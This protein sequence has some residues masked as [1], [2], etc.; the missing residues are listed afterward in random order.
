M[1][2]RS[3]ETLVSFEREAAQLTRTLVQARLPMQGL[4]SRTAGIIA[5]SHTLVRQ[6][7]ELIAGDPRANSQSGSRPA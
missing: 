7:D 2:H 5:E 3:W 1:Q 4:R 6:V